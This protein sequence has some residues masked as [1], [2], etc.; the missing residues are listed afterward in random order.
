MRLLIVED[1]V[2]INNL[3]TTYAKQEGYD[4]IS[5]FD[6]ADAL[7]ILSD[8]K[9]D[10]VITDLMMPKMQGED[11][12]KTLREV[13]NVF[14]IVVTAKSALQDKLDVLNLGADDYLVKPFSIDELLLKLKNIN[15]RVQTTKPTLLSFNNGMLKLSLLEP[16]VLVRDE[17]ITLTHHEYQVL[18]LLVTH[19]GQT[20]S[21]DQIIDH[22]FTESDAFDRMI[23]VYIK[24]LRKKL[25]DNAK[26]AR[27]IKTVYG[28]GYQFVGERDD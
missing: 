24:N 12:I 23:D 21:R 15:T 11:L 2:K 18:K 16:R 17:K 25:H 20:L 9:I 19:E 22:V 4:V 7:D 10:C 26:D 14:I 1:S 3:M 28:G 8:K 5:V 13:S 6:A 27:F